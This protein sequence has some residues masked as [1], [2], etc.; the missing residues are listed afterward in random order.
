M[1]SSDFCYNKH[2]IYSEAA[3]NNG[4]QGWLSHQ[5]KAFSGNKAGLSKR[6]SHPKK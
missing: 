6:S 2:F 4:E 1:F 5:S 3:K